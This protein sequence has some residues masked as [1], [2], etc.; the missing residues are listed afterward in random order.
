MFAVQCA[1]VLIGPPGGGKTTLAIQLARRFQA[2]LW[3]VGLVVD[4]GFDGSV[5]AACFTAHGF[6]IF[7][8]RSSPTVVAF[9]KI[10]LVE[11]RRADA[12]DVLPLLHGVAERYVVLG[13]FDQLPNAASTYGSFTDQL[14]WNP[15]TLEPNGFNADRLPVDPNTVLRPL[16][17]VSALTGAGV[18][19]LAAALAADRISTQPKP[20]SALTATD[21]TVAAAAFHFESSTEQS[22]DDLLARQSDSVFEAASAD[23]L[24]IVS[25]KSVGVSGSF[26]AGRYR[27]RDAVGLSWPKSFRT[28]RTARIVAEAVFEKAAAAEAFRGILRRRSTEAVGVH[29]QSFAARNAPVD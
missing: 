18:A 21:P 13:V 1:Y 14:V 7:D 20:G 4:P 8:P 5:D 16:M 29:L 23:G 26:F 11:S 2:K 22:L 15:P 3:T 12:G 24:P 27:R 28:A 10:L 25:W 17:T 9:P 19:D 6:R